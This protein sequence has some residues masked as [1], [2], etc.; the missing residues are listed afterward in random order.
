LV[1][2][3]SAGRARPVQF[4]RAY[5]VVGLPGTRAST[6]GFRSDPDRRR[7]LSQLPRLDERAPFNAHFTLILR[8]FERY[9]LYKVHKCPIG[10]IYSACSEGLDVMERTR[11]YARHTLVGL[12]LLC[13]LIQ[14]GRKQ[15]RLTAQDLAKRIG[16][17]R[18]TLQRIE[19]RR[20]QGRN[21]S[22]V[23]GGDHRRRA[24]VRYGRAPAAGAL[25]PHRRQNRGLAQ[26]RPQT[27]PG[28]R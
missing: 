21:R 11:T 14:L 13:K 4:A 8:Q 26:A 16:V 12:G 18:S 24:L 3:A 20:P 7:S 25:E 6:I 27:R 22:D 19:K 23:R 17:S 28:G 15:R 5:R 9:D 10:M 1:P 2:R